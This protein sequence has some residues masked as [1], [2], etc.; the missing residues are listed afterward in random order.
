MLAEAGEALALGADLRL[1]KGEDSSG[2]RQK[3][4]ILADAVEAVIGAVYVDGGLEP[5][6]ALIVTLLDHRIA[7]AASMPGAR[8][9]KTRLQEVAARDGESPPVYVIA[10]S[11][12]DH[13]K[14]FHAT[15]SIGS[16]IRGEGVGTSKKEAEQRAARAAW[17]GLSGG[18]GAT[19]V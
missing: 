14:Q 3:A 12:P 18:E 19:D 13:N 15:V 5:A 2:G 6:R 1:G 10:E 8:D 7:E 16:A 17:D 4:S 9:Y 11:G